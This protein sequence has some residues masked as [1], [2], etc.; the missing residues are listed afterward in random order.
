MKLLLIVPYV[1]NLIRVRPYQILRCLKRQGA[2]VTLATLWSGDDERNDLT[3]LEDLGVTVVAESLSRTRSLW[4]VARTLPS[5]RPLQAAFCWHPRLA[6]EITQLLTQERY[7]AV[8]VEHLRGALYG[9]HAQQVLQTDASAAPVTPVIWD[10]VDCISHLFQQAS[11]QS[12][13]LKGRVMTRLDLKRTQLFE[14]FLVN[15]FEHVITTSQT[16]AQALARLGWQQPSRGASNQGQR[17]ADCPNYREIISKITAIPNGVDLDYFQLDSDSPIR[18]SGPKNGRP[19][20]AHNNSQTIVFSGKMSYHANVTAALHLV[21]DIM[22]LVWQEYPSVGVQIV[23][24]DPSTEVQALA[25]RQGR[26]GEHARR[27]DV[28][29]T[30]PDLRPY[31]T[32]ATLSVA[33]VPYGAGIQN[34]VLEA[35]ACGVPVVASAQAAS[36]VE[37]IAGKELLV[38]EG[39]HQFADAICTLLRDAELRTTLSIAG[40]RY[41]EDHHSWD[42]VAQQLIQLYQ[43]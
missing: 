36:G 25:T 39:S 16:D 29:G 8:H 12:R 17:P 4:N 14:G 41:V 18:K 10:S 23:G 2:D 9:L 3:D 24:K 7:D 20:D 37:A 1:P 13:S 32:Q 40:R 11:E 15:Q 26:L 42:Q 38:A 19:D 31:L 43:T 35:M 5:Q 28:T 33:P 30:V 22:P 34:K 21:N 27:V 6:S